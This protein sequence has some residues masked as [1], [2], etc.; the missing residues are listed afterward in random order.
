[1]GIIKKDIYVIKNDINKKLY[2]GQS[3][4][5]EQ[6]FKS[7]C[8]RNRDNSLIDKAIQKY[9]KEHFWYEILEAQT[10]NYNEQEKYWI[11]HLNS[12]RPS[13]YN[14][15]SGGDEPPRFIGDANKSTKISDK[16]VLLLKEDLKN[17]T[18]SLNN[19]ACKYN[20]SKRQVLRI[21]QGI[22]RAKLNEEYPIRKNPN[23]SNKLSQEDVKLIIELLKFSYRLNG[24]IARQFGVEV[25]LISD[26][27]TGKSYFQQDVQYPIRKWKSCGKVSFT[28]EQVT[29]IN[30]L[31]KNTNLSFREIARQYNVTHNQISAICYGT[32]KKYLREDLTYPLRKPS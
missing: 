29:E 1:M 31:L 28:Y 23:S 32:T 30:S 4:N 27:N 14:I 15:L 24:E 25:H 7:H 2:I 21:N 6:R 19:L 5:A 3:L 20:V 26:I 22:S 9:G 11:S 18:I 13:G 10:E 12:L 16:N 8:K 17:T